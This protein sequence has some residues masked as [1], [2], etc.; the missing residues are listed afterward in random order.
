ML[1]QDRVRARIQLRPSGPARKKALSLAQQRA[2]AGVIGGVQQN[3]AALGA[4]PELP[5][6][7]GVEDRDYTHSPL[8]RSHKFQHIRP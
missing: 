6:S 7:L 2:A 5:V 1:P 8:T 4:A 3:V